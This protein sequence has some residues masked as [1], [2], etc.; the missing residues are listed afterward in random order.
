MKIKKR[1]LAL[2]AA[3]A[4]TFGIATPASAME[5]WEFNSVCKWQYGYSGARAVSGGNAYQ[6]QCYVLSTKL[7]GLNLY[8]YCVNV[9]G[10]SNVSLGNVN[11]PYSWRCV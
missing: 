9:M 5:Q 10:K 7:G 4:L 3:I 2:L 1:I 11:D 6:W 8:G